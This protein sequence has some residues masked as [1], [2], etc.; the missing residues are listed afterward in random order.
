M[1]HKPWET[2]KDT[3]LL[4]GDDGNVA[5]V[6]VYTGE[7]ITTLQSSGYAPPSS[8]TPTLGRC[9]CHIISQGNTVSYVEHNLN[10]ARG[11]LSIWRNRYPDFREQM[12][13]AR[14]SRAF[15]CEDKVFALA[16]SSYSDPTELA[17]AKFKADTYG[18]VAAWGNRQVF[19][20]SNDNTPSGVTFIINTGIDR[21]PEGH[22]G[23]T[24]NCEVSEAGTVDRHEDGGEVPPDSLGGD[25]FV[26]DSEDAPDDAVENI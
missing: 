21:T 23:K 4:L 26:A 7:V 5:E 14:K 10:L 12:E 17:E 13:A 18:K 24:I 25:A 8:Y 9:A 19:G 6:D 1:Y 11:T 22:Y 16:E 20:S 2:M 3:E 15:Y